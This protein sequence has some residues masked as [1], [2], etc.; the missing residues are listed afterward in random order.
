MYQ[1]YQKAGFFCLVTLLTYDCIST[2]I[3][4]LL[5]NEITDFRV[6]I[7]IAFCP[8]NLSDECHMY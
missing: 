1:R 7:S 4:D 6:V 2:H 5:C 3:I 8:L